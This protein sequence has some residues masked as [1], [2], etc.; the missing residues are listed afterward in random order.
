MPEPSAPGSVLADSSIEVVKPVLEDRSSRRRV[1]LIVAGG[2][3]AYKAPELVRALIAGGCAVQVVMTPAARAF[4]SELA[5]ATVSTRPVRSSL[6]DPAEEGRV[7]HI[8]LADWPELVLVAPATAD[9]MA[10]AAA[11]LADDLAAC[12]LLATRAPVLWAPAMN[13]NMWRHAATRHNLATLRD[14]GAEFVGPD[15]G[16]LACGWIGEGRMIDPPLIVA[17][18]TA[19]LAGAKDMSA[20]TGPWRGRRVLISAGPTR[21]YIDPVRFVSN[22]STGAMGFALAAA[23]QRLGAEVTLVAGPVELATPPGVRRVDVETAPQMHA[24]LEQSLAEAPVDL[25]AMVAA[26]SDLEVDASTQKLDKATLLPT[27]ADLRWRTGVD[28]LAS[29]TARHGASARRPFFLGFAAQTVA[30]GPEVEAE[31]LRLGAAKLA[32]KRVD[33]IFVNRVGVPGLGFASATNAGY[34]L[35]RAPGDGPATVKPS[36]PPVAKEQLADWMLGELATALG[37]ADA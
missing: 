2:I 19:L 20:G 10:R 15:R 25:V 9:L 32:S 31:L 36:G 18:A 3:A 4:V 26:V 37:K 13:T 29:L 33:A 30:D 11:G 12:V 17:A 7:G 8:E 27:M 23:A 14:R 16:E 6:L 24:A 1:L 21:T 5:L 22:A 28:I 35:L 34:L